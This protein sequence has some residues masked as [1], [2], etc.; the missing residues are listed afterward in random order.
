MVT[1]PNTPESESKMEQG[2]FDS[3]HRPPIDSPVQSDADKAQSSIN[4]SHSS[5]IDS[6]TKEGSTGCRNIS[7]KCQID[8]HFENHM[9][10]FSGCTKEAESCTE[11]FSGKICPGLKLQELMRS[12]AK[13][14][15]E[16]NRREPL[17]TEIPIETNSNPSSAP[18]QHQAAAFCFANP[19]L[20]GWLSGSVPRFVGSSA[21]CTPFPNIPSEKRRRG[22]IPP[23]T[24]AASFVHI[25]RSFSRRLIFY[26]AACSAV[27][28]AAPASRSRCTAPPPALPPE[29]PLISIWRL[30]RRRAPDNCWLAAH[31]AVYDVTLLLKRHPGG[32]RVLLKRAGGDCSEDFDFHSTVGR[33]MWARYRIG[34]LVPPA[35]PGERC[36]GM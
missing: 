26:S 15:D 33:E 3:P 27:E 17:V 29:P 9:C 14:F 11:C 22:P 5:V 13:D 35:D 4:P 20:P 21:S 10:F 32:E 7:G 18:L 6:S 28:E 1:D 2:S 8:D 36:E 31:G 12:P 16:S 24:F 34:A 23:T 30:R 25:W 19:I